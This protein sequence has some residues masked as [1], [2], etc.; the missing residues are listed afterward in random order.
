MGKNDSTVV[1]SCWADSA[2]MKD[3]PKSVCSHVSSVIYFKWW[4]WGFQSIS[5][6][7]PSFWYI[8]YLCSEQKSRPFLFGGNW[9]YIGKAI[10]AYVCGSIWNFLHKSANNILRRDLIQQSNAV[11][12]RKKQASF[13]VCSKSVGWTMN[14]FYLDFSSHVKK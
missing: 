1:F 9:Q 14:I 7:I 12:L 11:G 2:G 10:G 8:I 3:S 5:L 13:S 4:W 6:G